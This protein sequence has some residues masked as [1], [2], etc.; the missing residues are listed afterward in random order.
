[1]NIFRNNMFRFFLF[2]GLTFFVSIVGDLDINAKGLPV[3]TYNIEFPKNQTDTT[4]E[5]YDLKV[6]KG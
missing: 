2:M 3:F 1:M 4:L 6:K 5:Y